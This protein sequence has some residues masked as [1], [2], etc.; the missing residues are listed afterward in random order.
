MWLGA[1]R[2]A[3]K[4]PLAAWKLA[5]RSRENRE[6]GIIS[7]AT[8]NDALLLKNFHKF[9]NKNGFAMGSVDMG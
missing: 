5:T 9:Y 4:P 6:M 7:L 3:R 8:Q 2:N 1:N